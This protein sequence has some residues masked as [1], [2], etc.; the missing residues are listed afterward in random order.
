MKYKKGDI[1]FDGRHFVFKPGIYASLKQ[2]FWQTDVDHEIDKAERWLLYNPPKK[3]FTKYLCNWLNNGSPKHRIAL[4][5]EPRDVPRGKNNSQM[6]RADF[7][8]ALE[9]EINHNNIKSL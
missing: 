7:Q 6:K 1:A 8:S 4:K 9:K 3:D 5:D 2:N